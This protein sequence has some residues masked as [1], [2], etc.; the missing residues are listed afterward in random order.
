ML[1]EYVK[2]D[3]RDI[4]IEYLNEGKD[5]DI[6]KDI[7]VIRNRKELK[8]W[9]R[10]LYVIE[11]F[12][13]NKDIY[14]DLIDSMFNIVKACFLIKPC[15]EFPIKFK[16]Y[17]H[18]KEIHTLQLR[19][20]LVNLIY[21]K[22]FCI[23]NSESP[24]NK[25]L[26]MNCFEIQNLESFINFMLKTVRSYHVKETLISYS[27]SDVLYRMREISIIFSLVMNTT[28]D[29][30][31]FTSMY[32]KYGRMKEIME[33]KFS[34][35]MQPKDIEEEL[36]TFEREI[37]EMFKAEPNNPV[38]V[39]LRSRTGMKTKQLREY[40]AANGLRPTLDSKTI[41]IAMENST[42]LRGI[43]RPSY[44]FI[45]ANGSSKSYVM[46]KKVMGNAGYFSKIVIELA[47]TLKI[48]T[49]VSN[50]DTAYLV[51][52]TI[53]NGRFLKKMVGKYFKENN[54]PDEELKLLTA[55]DKQYIGKTI[56]CR[57]VAT[58]NC[59]DEVCGTCLGKIAALNADITS[60]YSIYEAEESMKSFQQDVLSTKHLLTTL[61]EEIR[62][63]K[64]F[65]SFFTILSSEINPIINNNEMIDNIDDWVIYFKPEDISS[66]DDMDDFS[67]FSLVVDSKFYIKNIKDPSN[68][69]LIETETPK[70]LYISED[71]Y[72][73]M[74][75]NNGTI[76]FKYLDDDTKIFDIDILN[77]EL[78]KPLYAIMALINKKNKRPKNLTIESISQ[79]YMDYLVESSSSAHC[80]GAE[81]IINRLIRDMK[82]PYSRPDFS[83]PMVPPSYTINTVSTALLGNK[84]PFVG[85]AYQSQKKQYL[86][87]ELFEYRHGESYI[88]P[89]FKENISTENLKKYAQIILDNEE[90]EESFEYYE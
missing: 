61:S 72:A 84:S 51:P 42:L 66:V 65:Y 29:I 35:D 37:V 11:D 8:Q 5:V 41:P 52:Y 48:S 26:I 71:A 40:V 62:F 2:T 64:E 23:L 49:T 53:R 46:N 39:I 50:C 78:T 38:G 59:G 44:C 18:D 30:S 7:P 34:P 31:H 89:L 68:E 32:Q 28:M 19:H 56:W 9:L 63:N 76:P 33:S 86:S 83:N 82:D 22:P 6:T 67:A 1:F 81:I 10:P 21:W 36:N 77:N 90:K 87:D 4:K 17:H 80:V 45:D 3:D 74:K 79:L 73:I 88:D 57:S 12:Q 75:D 85:L 25:D 15:R 55:D 54:D 58:C 24:L 16:F 14:D 20:F 43:D 69:I 70:E 47:A 13:K 27:T 60:G